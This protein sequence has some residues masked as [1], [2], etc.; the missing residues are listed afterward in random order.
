MR[1]PCVFGLLT[2]TAV[3][4]VSA[5]VVFDFKDTK[6]FAFIN[7]ENRLKM[8]LREF[9]GEIAYVIADGNEKY[10]DTYWALQTPPFP[11]KA[12]RTFAVKVRT[13]S[14]IPL[15]N[16]NPMSA[17]LWYA[18]GGKELLAQDALG[19]DS[20]V[21]TPMPVR[22][23]PTAYRDSV[24][25]GVVP[26]GAMFASVRMS[27]D[28]PQIKNGQIVAI[29]RIEYVERE[30]GQ[31]WAYD[32]LTPPK[33]ERLTP[34]PNPDFNAAVSFRISDPSGVGRVTIHLD[35]TDV[36]E[37]VVFSGDVATYTPTTP[38]AEDSIHEFVFSVEDGRGNDALESRFV[39]FTRG[40]VAHEKVTVRDDGV[41][42]IVPRSRRLGRPLRRLGRDAVRRHVHS[43]GVVLRASL[44]FRRNRRGGLRT[45]RVE[46]GL[47]FVR[48]P[49]PG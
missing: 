14:D 8:N 3:A 21:M 15:S 27:A 48:P 33:I 35:G 39:C 23:S 38:W 45:R 26:E 40:K 47:L 24:V 29:S 31:P 30:V 4:Q 20:Q 46:F 28:S 41:G 17:V 49:S 36:T 42:R 43:P 6:G 32:D 44:P 34:S 1:V 22:T 37:R 16:T 7:Y 18:E 13:R 2:A 5:A 12:G 19:Q 25:A 11:V 9:G 10:C